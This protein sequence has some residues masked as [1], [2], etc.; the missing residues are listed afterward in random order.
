MKFAVFP[1]MLISCV[2]ALLQGV[3]I[4]TVG[5]A[6]QS[7]SAPDVLRLE[8]PGAMIRAPGKPEVGLGLRFIPEYRLGDYENKVPL[9]SDRLTL[10]EHLERRAA[11]RIGCQGQIEGDVPGGA[12][13]PIPPENLVSPTL[14]NNKVVL[15]G[16]VQKTIPGWDVVRERAVTLVAVRIREVLTDRKQLGFQPG[17][18]ISYIQEFGSFVHGGRRFWTVDPSSIA[19]SVGDRIV[20]AADYDF[21]NPSNVTPGGIFFLRDGMVVPAR[22]QYL[23]QPVSPVSVENMHRELKSNHTEKE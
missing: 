2:W 5:A 8:R 21:A 16:D 1:Y 9:S 22:P 15:I 13:P 20:V 10:R 23:G 6:A 17:M 4:S 11:S 12:S 19:V 3:L 7:P 14:R 18:Q